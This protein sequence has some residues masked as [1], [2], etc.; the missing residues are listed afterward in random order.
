[1]CVGVA[2]NA[3]YQLLRLNLARTYTVDFQKVSQTTYI[4]TYIYMY[5]YIYISK[6]KSF[7]G[8]IANK[9]RNKLL[10]TIPI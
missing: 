7:G 10:M 3:F 8:T 5:I 6:E 4:Y 9:D 2:C 1:M